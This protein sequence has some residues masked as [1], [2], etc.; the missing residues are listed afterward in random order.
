MFNEGIQILVNCFVFLAEFFQ[1]LFEFR[2]TLN[3]LEHHPRNLLQNMVES[4]R[5]QLHIQ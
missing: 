1:I 2:E 3:L 5:R 4:Y